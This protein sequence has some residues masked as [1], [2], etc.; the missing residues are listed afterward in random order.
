MIKHINTS[1][2]K[3]T[4]LLI[5]LF[6]FCSLVFAQKSKYTLEINPFARYDRTNEF[7]N[8]ETV[9][10]GK[11]Y[12]QPSGI[13][14]GINVNVKRKLRNND[15]IY[16]GPGYYRHTIYNIKSR[17]NRG[18][19]DNGRI[20]NFFSP[21]FIFFYTDRYAYNNISLN[22]GYERLF[23][24]NKNYTLITGIDL[25]ALH[26]FSQYYH[27]K[28]NPEG[29]VDYKQNNSTPLGLFVGFDVGLLKKYKQ[30]SIGPKIKIPVFSM[31]K[32]DETFPNETGTDFRNQWFSGVGLGLSFIYNF[33]TKK[34]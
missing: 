22:I 33:K 14:Y 29:S 15:N 30:F 32:T 20:I 10:S 28:R 18:V 12:I 23:R 19:T 9:T 5:A 26:T 25:N 31:L 8:W 6:L 27:L 4:G 7:N 11:N 17:N 34:L 2:I 3:K 16:A 21:L 13:S 1:I 24:L